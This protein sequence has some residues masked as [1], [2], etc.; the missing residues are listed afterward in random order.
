M[1]VSHQT[2]SE[3]E[4]LRIKIAQLKKVKK[5]TSRCLTYPQQVKISCNNLISKGIKV[6]DIA[7][8]TGIPASTLHC[9]H[10]IHNGKQKRNICGFRELKIINE[11]NIPSTKRSN[12]DKIFIYLPGKIKLAVP[13]DLTGKMIQILK[14]VQSVSRQ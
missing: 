14:E 5:S 10:S 8:A 12:I 13:I 4:D 9:W 2:K 3:L 7:K 11:K 1:D 6:V